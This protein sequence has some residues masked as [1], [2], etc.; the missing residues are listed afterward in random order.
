MRTTGAASG[1]R[2]KIPTVLGTGPLGRGTIR[3]ATSARTEAR[4]QSGA[5]TESAESPVWPATT[6]LSVRAR[7]CADCAL[8]ISSAKASS[9]CNRRATAPGL[10]LVTAITTSSR[11]HAGER[12]CLGNAGQG[13]ALFS[14][15]LVR[16][17][18]ALYRADRRSSADCVGSDYLA[19]VTA[20]LTCQA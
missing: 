17:R 14:D 15:P 1:V 2:A 18:T 4:M 7:P 10:T 9:G 5:E 20:D 16:R 13:S 11:Y 6:G 8:I 3:H 19:T 12:S